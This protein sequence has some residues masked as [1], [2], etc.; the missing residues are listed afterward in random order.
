MTGGAIGAG[1]AEALL[2]WTGASFIRNVKRFEK[3]KG[4]C[5]GASP[6]TPSLFRPRQ[7]TSRTALEWSYRGLK[8]RSPGDLQI[9][10]RR[11][12][13]AASVVVVPGAACSRSEECLMSAAGTSSRPVWCQRAA[14]PTMEGWPRKPRPPVTPRRRV[15]A[16]LEDRK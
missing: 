5:G 9:I 15:K 1:T 4:V 7:T 13:T 12:N 11:P 10:W 8:P 16:R 14:R 6:L 3:V 2:G